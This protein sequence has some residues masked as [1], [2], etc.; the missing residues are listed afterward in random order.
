MTENTKPTP[1]SQPEKD[2]EGVSPSSKPQPFYKHPGVIA[3]GV[4][5]LVAIVLLITWLTSSKTP[6]QA[7]ATRT[8]AVPLVLVETDD[9][10]TSVE[11]PTQTL[12]PVPTQKQP[13]P[14]PTALPRTEVITY[15][16]QEGDTVSSIAT[17][18]NLWP[19]TILWANRYELGDDIRNFTPG[20]TIFI[21]PVDGVYHTWSAGE[22]LGAVSKY[23][24]V[25]PEDIINFPANKLSAETIGNYSS[26][27]IAAGTRLVVPGGTLPNYFAS[28]N[29]LYYAAVEK[30]N[31]LPLGDAE[32]FPA[33]RKEIIA[34]EVQ[35]L[36]SIFSIAEKFG[37]LPETILWSNRYLIGDT[38]DGSSPGQ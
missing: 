28:D 33:P 13:T 30:L 10:T 3:S 32:S 12:A 14:E 26:P 38:P 18:F 11:A 22:G 8:V 9:M 15:T 27:N 31:S 25:T 36:D 19:E 34:Y 7:E 2:A 23:Y 17:K 29:L 20:T 24:G 35:P 1:G 5:I 4:L 21:L 37:L 16:I 6:T